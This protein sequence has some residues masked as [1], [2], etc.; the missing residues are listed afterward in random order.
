MQVHAEVSQGGTDDE[1]DHPRERPDGHGDRGALR[2]RIR[3]DRKARLVEQ[4]PQVSTCHETTSNLA[5]LT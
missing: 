2:M 1:A 4:S 5:E 3:E